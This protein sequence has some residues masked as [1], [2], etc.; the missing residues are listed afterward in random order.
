[1]EA[2]L[3]VEA[4]MTGS[5]CFPDKGDLCSSLR[6]F[7]G[8][9]PLSEIHSCLHNKSCMTCEWKLMKRSES[10]ST[11]HQIEDGSVFISQCP[12]LPLVKLKCRGTRSSMTSAMSPNP[13]SP[14]CLFKEVL[15]NF[16]NGSVSED[17]PAVLIQ[18]LIV[19]SGSAIN[20]PALER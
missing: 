16:V 18:K 12:D 17:L 9:L 19:R 7:S 4:R 13:I 2:W 8:S 6:R 3:A 15:W 11:A 5:W 14:G 10:V 1:M 20:D